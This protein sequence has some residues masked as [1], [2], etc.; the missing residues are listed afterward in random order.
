[1]YIYKKLII[2]ANV[3]TFTVANNKTIRKIELLP[4]FLDAHNISIIG[5]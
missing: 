1:M 3:K 4:S 2:Q 5:T